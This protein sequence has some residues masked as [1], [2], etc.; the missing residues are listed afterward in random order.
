M[1]DKIRT[2]VLVANGFGWKRIFADTLFQG[3]LSIK[4]ISDVPQV[5]RKNRLIKTA[6]QDGYEEQ[7]YIADWCESICLSPRLDVTLCNINDLIDYRSKRKYAKEYELIMVLHSAA[8][9]DMRILLGTADWFQE[10]RGKLVVFIGNEY[11]LLDEKIRFINRSGADYVCSQLPIEAALWLYSDCVHTRVLEM[12][13]ALNHQLYKVDEKIPR[14][15]DIGFRGHPYPLFLGDVERNTFLDHFQRHGVDAGLVCD[16]RYEK[17]KRSDWARYLQTCHGIV[18]AES[19]TYFLDRKGNLIAAAKAYLQRHPNASF[20][21]IRERFFSHL[22]A[23][24]SGKAI[25]S[26][27]FEPIGTKTCQI[28]LEGKYNGILEADTHYISVKKDFSDLK[29]AVQRYKDGAYRGKIID[30]AYQHVMSAHTYQHR[31]DHLLRM[32]A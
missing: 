17:I 20:D 21:E 28:L 8:G 29:D 30:Q 13:H 4:D 6:F 24:V 10:R 11:D 5:F 32:V 25:S 9:D 31:V 22:P 23:H 15:I 3:V 19:G 18:G 26:R 14:T 7:S 2:L 1:K 16:I 27:H 12:P